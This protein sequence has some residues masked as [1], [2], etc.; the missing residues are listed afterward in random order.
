[1]LSVAVSGSRPF[2]VASLNR[3][4]AFLDTFTCEL[5][6]GDDH[7]IGLRP[8]FFTGGLGFAS[9]YRASALPRWLPNSSLETRFVPIRSHRR[10]S[11]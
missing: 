3:V 4:S 1:M 10:S 2:L 11:R 7:V 6:D 9:G 8:A 5:M